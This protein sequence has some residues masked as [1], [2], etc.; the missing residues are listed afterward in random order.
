MEENPEQP[1]YMP[2]KLG[3]H[4][5]TGDLATAE[6]MKM[7]ERH[8]MRTVAKMADRIADG[9]LTPDPIIR[10]QR[11]SCDYCDYKTVCHKD[12]DTQQVRLFAQTSAAKFWEILEQEEKDH[13]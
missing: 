12:L 2:Y 7:L 6:Q 11:S 1:L 9:E 5:I 10:G 3:R 8:V 4:G 13:G